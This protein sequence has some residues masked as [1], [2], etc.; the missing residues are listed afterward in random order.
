MIDSTATSGLRL[1]SLVLA[2]LL[3][4]VACAGCTSSENKPSSRSG[5]STP[6]G[7]DVASG[8]DNG[9]A[10]E[11]TSAY[12]RFFDPTVAN[13]LRLDL[14]QDGAAFSQAIAKQ[15]QTDFAKAASM[16]VTRVS[17]NSADKAT[18]IFTV[19]LDGAPV[20]PNQTGYAVHEAGKWKVAGVTFCALLAA[21][22]PLPPVCR[23]PAATSLP[24]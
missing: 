13:A 4:T 14:I 18:V 19:L 12:V 3:F 22:G 11:V 9:A 20:L 1:R 6:T 7:T 10:A 15:S 5:A 2:C 16:H 8:V 24:S 21:A 23:S 17:V